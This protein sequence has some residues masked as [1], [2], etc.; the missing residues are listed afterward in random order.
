MTECQKIHISSTSRSEVNR[1]VSSHS[2]KKKTWIKKRSI[3]GNGLVVIAA[4]W[5]DAMVVGWAG[6]EKRYYGLRSPTKRIDP[7]M[8]K[9]SHTS[10]N[11][12]FCVRH[13]ELRK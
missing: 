11:R 12:K 5:L 13:Q 6:E 1:Q 8:K 7:R 3:R 10:L 4:H 9:G 2:T